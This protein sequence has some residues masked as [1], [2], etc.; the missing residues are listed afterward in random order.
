MNRGDIIRM[1][2]EAELNAHGLVIDRLERFAALVAAHER[3][4]C[5]EIAERK[6]SKTWAAPKSPK[7]WWEMACKDISKEI[8][9]R[10]PA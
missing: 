4:A 7:E 6:I 5:A 2:Q 8:R 3:E 10:G 1:A 9:A